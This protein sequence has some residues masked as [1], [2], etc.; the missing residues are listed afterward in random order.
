[1]KNIKLLKV[2][3]VAKI[4]NCSRQ[5]A[6]NIIKKLNNELEKKGY[7]INVG[8]IPENYF[9]DRFNYSDGA[10]EMEVTE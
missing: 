6:Y 2:N 9:L 8:S 1:M 10:K 4:L 7:L 3:D 5:K